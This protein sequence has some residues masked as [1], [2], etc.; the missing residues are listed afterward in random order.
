MAERELAVGVVGATGL[1][2]R[3]VLRLLDERGFPSARPRLFG[4]TRTAGGNL[5]DE[6]GTSHGMVEL[7]GPDSFVDL[8]LVFFTAGPGAAPAPPPPPPAQ[9]GPPA[10]P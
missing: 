3:E 9:G 10:A 1:G 8:D 7:L 6:E 5:D 4:T 2:G